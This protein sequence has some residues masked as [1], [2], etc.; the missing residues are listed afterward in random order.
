MTW[1]FSNIKPNDFEKLETAIRGHDK[2]TMVFIHDKYEVSKVAL[3][4]C[5]VKVLDEFLIEIEFW[6]FNLRDEQ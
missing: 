4:C 1:N 6:Y 3:C 5:D 2:A